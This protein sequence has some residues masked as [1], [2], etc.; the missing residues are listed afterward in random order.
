M[1][2]AIPSVSQTAAPYFCTAGFQPAL[3][4]IPRARP[5]HP[6]RHFRNLQHGVHLRANTLQLP[7]LLQP[8]HKLTQVSVRHCSLLSRRTLPRT[9]TH[10]PRCPPSLPQAP[11]C[12]PFD[13][14]RP[15]LLSLALLLDFVGPAFLGGPLFSL[16]TTNRA[17]ST[18]IQSHL[19]PQSF[20]ADTNCLRLT[21]N[22]ASRPLFR[23]DP[24]FRTP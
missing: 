10:S 8:L 18:S 9:S 11:E 3:L 6:L 2:A 22:A 23:F 7:F 15:A 5:A 19:E 1:D 16:S 24:Y 4:F 17:G 21:I 12:L 13:L 14:L 20:Q